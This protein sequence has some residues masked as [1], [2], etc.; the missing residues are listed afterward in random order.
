MLFTGELLRFASS[1]WGVFTMF[2]LWVLYQVYSPSWL[3]DTK[4]QKMVGEVRDEVVETKHMLVSTITVLRAV[5]RTNDDVST[6]KVDEYLVE[7]GVQPDD[8]IRETDL[9]NTSTTSESHGDD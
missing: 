4:L 9:P 6:E 3:P 7:N 8:F 5:V 2:F 1:Q